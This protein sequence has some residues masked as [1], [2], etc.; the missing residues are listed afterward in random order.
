MGELGEGGEIS[1]AAWNLLIIFSPRA[2]PQLDP[3][4]SLF[5]IIVLLLIAALRAFV[6]YTELVFYQSRS[7]HSI[8]LQRI[9]PSGLQRE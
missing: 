6:H 5:V 9:S 2:G 8:Y 1:I 7:V 4:K 3:A